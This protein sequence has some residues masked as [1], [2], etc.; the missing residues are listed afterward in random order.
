MD[1]VDKPREQLDVAA[2]FAQPQT[3]AKR[4]PGLGFR[5][6]RR[7]A[8]GDELVDPAFEMEGGLLVQRAIHP[9]W[10]ERIRQA[11]QPGHRVPLCVLEHVIDRRGDCLL[12][13]SPSPR[14][15]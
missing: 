7:Q 1:T 12:Y 3:I 15:S 2:L 6:L 9:G 4:A 8:C 5:L 11:R 14:D 10:P 13:T